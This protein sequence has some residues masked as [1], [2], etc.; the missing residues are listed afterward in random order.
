MSNFSEKD[1]PLDVRHG[2]MLTLA[3]GTTV[4]FESSGEAK[5]VMVNDAFAPAVT[6]FPGSEYVLHTGGGDYRVTCE[7]GDCMHVEKV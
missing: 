5:D 7:F 3:D 4:R 2:E 1:L 6:L